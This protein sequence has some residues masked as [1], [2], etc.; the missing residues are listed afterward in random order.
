MRHIFALDEAHMLLI[1]PA[2]FTGEDA[3]QFK[4]LIKDYFASY[5]LADGADLY[6]DVHPVTRIDARGLSVMAF[7]HTDIAHRP[8]K[9]IEPSKNMLRHLES[10]RL[11][12]HFDIYF[13]RK[14][15]MPILLSGADDRRYAS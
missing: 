15:V 1:P 13:D 6:F 10:L 9:V 4:V 8:L 2:D 3:Y 7:L 12:E 14:Y 11:F 5:P